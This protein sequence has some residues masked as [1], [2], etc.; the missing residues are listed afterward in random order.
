MGWVFVCVCGWLVFFFKVSNTGIK[1]TPACSIP[2][3]F[4]VW[5]SHSSHMCEYTEALGWFC[6][7]CSPGL[8][9]PGKVS[10]LKLILQSQCA[11]ISRTVGHKWPLILC[12]IMSQT[13][14]PQTQLWKFRCVLCEIKYRGLL[15]RCPHALLS[16]ALLSGHEILPC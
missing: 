13:W 10:G 9:E 5:R 1:S 11:W 12:L 6:L 3:A 15:E 14:V 16:E 8:V 2:S 7:Y 4:L